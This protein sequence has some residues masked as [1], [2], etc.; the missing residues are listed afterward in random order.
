MPADETLI[1]RTAALLRDVRRLVR[2]IEELKKQRE[3]AT[4]ETAN[5]YTMIIRD[6]T[7]E[8]TTLIGVYWREALEK[9]HPDA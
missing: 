6:L 1:H 2:Q 3:R 7:W 4:G 9:T 5:A 8:L